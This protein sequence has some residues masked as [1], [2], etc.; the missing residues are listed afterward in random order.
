MGEIKELFRSV[1]E[2]TKIAGDEI[3]VASRVV[4]AALEELPDS[5]TPLELAMRTAH[6]AYLEATVALLRCIDTLD[7]LRAHFTKTGMDTKL[8]EDLLTTLNPV[9]ALQAKSLEILEDLQVTISKIE[10]AFNRSSTLS[11]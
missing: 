9:K 7:E 8:V 2:K 5:L 6:E 1:T 10:L 3:G 11:L 4:L